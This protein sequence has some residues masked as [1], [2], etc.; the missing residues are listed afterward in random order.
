[1]SV[2]KQNI[3]FNKFALFLNQFISVDKEGGIFDEGV[4]DLK[5]TSFVL[6]K[7]SEILFVDSTTGAKTILHEITSDRGVSF[8]QALDIFVDHQIKQEKKRALF[9]RKGSVRD[10]TATAG[11]EEGGMNNDEEDDEDNIVDSDEEDEEAQLVSGGVSR[12]DSDP[13]KIQSHEKKCQF[14]VSKF[15]HFGRGFSYLLAKQKSAQLYIVTRPNSGQS[16][17]EM[18]T[19][20]LFGKYKLL[21]YDDIIMKCASEHASMADGSSFID[22][23]CSQN[24]D[25]VKLVEGWSATYDAAADPEYPHGKRIFNVAIIG[26]AILPVWALTEEVRVFICLFVCCC[27][28]KVNR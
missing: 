20:E 8:K 23:M 7:P 26:G 27:F 18:T 2:D 9:E 13:S 1:M 15:N 14:F 12:I 17:Y 21:E 24:P 3:I 16:I 10:D 5:G 11:S 6:S 22:Y 25:L 28:F 4:S 19:T